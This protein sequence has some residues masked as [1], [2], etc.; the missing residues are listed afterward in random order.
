VLESAAILG[1][2]RAS[3]S[4]AVVSIHFSI[5]KSSYIVRFHHGRLVLL[6]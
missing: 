5:V 2:L 3:S 6:C 4:D 1:E